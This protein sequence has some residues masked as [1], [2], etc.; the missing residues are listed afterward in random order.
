MYRIYMS[1][2]ICSST[3]WQTE[4]IVEIHKF[5]YFIFKHNIWICQW[6]HSFGM[7]VRWLFYSQYAHY[8]LFV[9]IPTAK[10]KCYGRVIN[11]HHFRLF[12]SSCCLIYG[13]RVDLICFE[14]H[15]PE[16]IDQRLSSGELKNRLE[17]QLLLKFSKMY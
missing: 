14:S 4:M 12:P 7:I 5:N 3:K 16:E 8:R 13:N 1:S 6:P 2:S 15:N 10:F 17:M 9:W 11:T